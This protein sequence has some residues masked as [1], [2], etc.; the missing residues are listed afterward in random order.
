MSIALAR[1]ELPFAA[2][3]ARLCLCC[4]IRHQLFTGGQ[5]RGWKLAGTP[6]LGRIPSDWN[7]RRKAELLAQAKAEL[8]LEDGRDWRAKAEAAKLRQ[9]ILRVKVRVGLGRTIRTPTRHQDA[10]EWEHDC[11]D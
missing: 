2:S 5:T 11:M 4:V 10:G 8:A 1:L 6:L 7:G 9:A 3:L